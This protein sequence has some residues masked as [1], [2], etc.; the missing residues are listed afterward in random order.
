MREMF[1]A[2]DKANMEV[3]GLYNL[4]RDQVRVAPMGGV[5][6]LD[7]GAVLG[8]IKLYNTDGVKSIFE[9]ILM[10]H[11]VEQEFAKV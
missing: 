7:H 3:Y 4:V 1:V 8:V 9:G 11:Q 2:L 6:G 5:I 10:C